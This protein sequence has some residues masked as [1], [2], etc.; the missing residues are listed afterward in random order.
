[1]FAYLTVGASAEF[2]WRPHYSLMSDIAT[3]T[4]V[5]TAPPQCVSACN[6]DPVL[7]VIGIQKGPL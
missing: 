5:I 7:G 2:L 4:S 3:L 1:M 6:K